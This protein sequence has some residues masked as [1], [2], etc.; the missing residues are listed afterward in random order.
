MS[1]LQNTDPSELN[2]DLSFQV[3]VR[4]YLTVQVLMRPNS[5]NF[6]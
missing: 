6:C 2:L 3:I 5:L 4:A 1:W